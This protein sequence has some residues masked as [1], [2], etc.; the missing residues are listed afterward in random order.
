MDFT[1]LDANVKSVKAKRGILMITLNMRSSMQVGQIRN[2]I[3][4]VVLIASNF[5]YGAAGL[6]LLVMAV[7]FG[8]LIS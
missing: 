1:H 4:I 8:R 7:G 2:L 6:G 3:E 5:L